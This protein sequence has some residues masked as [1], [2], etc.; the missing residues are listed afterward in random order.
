MHANEVLY[1]VASPAT[2]PPVSFIY[3]FFVLEQGFINCLYRAVQPSH[4]AAGTL[5]CWTALAGALH[6]ALVLSISF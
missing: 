1:W 6:V 3:L 2:P 4:A 5:L